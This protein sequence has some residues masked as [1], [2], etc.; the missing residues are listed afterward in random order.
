ML[1]R[2]GERSDRHLADYF[3][4]RSMDTPP[5]HGFLD[6]DREILTERRIFS[7]IFIR[8]RPSFYLELAFLW[9]NKKREINFYRSN[10]SF[11]DKPILFWK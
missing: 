7:P 9:T 2:G 11:N 6:H 8:N 1:S 4:F 3:T 5:P 10:L